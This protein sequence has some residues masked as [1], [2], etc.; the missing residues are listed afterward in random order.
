M[1]CFFKVCAGGTGTAFCQRSPTLQVEGDVP[2]VWL[3]SDRSD[4]CFQ[5]I[6]LTGAGVEGGEGDQDF[7]VIGLSGME[8]AEFVDRVV[9]LTD[10]GEVA[11]ADQAQLGQA[12]KAGLTVFGAVYGDGG[13]KGGQRAGIRSLVDCGAGFFE[14]G[15]A[16]QL[17]AELGGGAI[18][19]M[20]AVKGCGCGIPITGGHL[21][22]AEQLVRGGLRFA[23]CWAVLL[24]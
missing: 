18:G 14:V 10:V 24:Y 1:Q 8:A 4:D 21:Q 3:S 11:G 19:L 17:T 23:A 12:G 13:I 2:E 7:E 16:A 20:V 6:P 15:F 5:C 9:A 22:Q